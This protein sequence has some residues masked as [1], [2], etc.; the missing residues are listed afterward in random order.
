MESGGGGQF[1][2]WVMAARRGTLSATSVHPSFPGLCAV[3]E[4]AP[5]CAS[6]AG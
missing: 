5:S 2:G 1:W 3:Q 6:L 4:R